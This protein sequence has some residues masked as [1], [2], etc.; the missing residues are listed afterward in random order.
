MIKPII[1]IIIGVII[2]VIVII[3]G[4]MA[5]S[6]SPIDLLEEIVESKNCQKLEAWDRSYGSDVNLDIPSELYSKAIKLGINCSFEVAGDMFG[7]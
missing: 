3:A 4:I 2:L 6:G 1:P 7:K 5:L